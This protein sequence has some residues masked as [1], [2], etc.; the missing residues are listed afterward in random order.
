MREGI[1]AYAAGESYHSHIKL[2]HIYETLQLILD[3]KISE[4]SDDRIQNPKEIYIAGKRVFQDCH[5]NP[6]EPLYCHLTFC[7]V[8]K[9]CKKSLSCSTVLL[10]RRKLQKNLAEQVCSYS[11]ISISMKSIPLIFPHSL[12]VP[13]IR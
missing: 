3:H 13:R 2:L 12:P 10:H 7:Q 5:I 6:W 4:Q 9:R 8:F 11:V 1:A